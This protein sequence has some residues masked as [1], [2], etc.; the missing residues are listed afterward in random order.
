MIYSFEG[1][2]NDSH[3]MKCLVRFGVWLL[4]IVVWWPLVRT[5]MYCIVPQIPGDEFG[6][7][8]S[9]GIKRLR[10]RQNGR[11]FADDTFKRIFTNENV[12]ILIEISLKFVPKG[13][14]NNFPALVHI[15]AW[16]CPGDKPLSERM[17]VSLATHI[18]VTRPQWVKRWGW[19]DF[20]RSNLYS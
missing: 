19:W 2:F 13:P 11:H 6:K 17:M 7:I 12:R 14:I 1:F 9:R 20:Y 10:P 4:T 5:D 3:Y 18:Y 15:M 8:L 16:R